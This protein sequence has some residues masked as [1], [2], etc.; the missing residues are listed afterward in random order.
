MNR[1]TT[2][3]TANW[4]EFLGLRAHGLRRPSRRLTPANIIWIQHAAPSARSHRRPLPISA[5]C[6]VRDGW[7]TVTYSVLWL[8]GLIA[9]ALCWF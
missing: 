6:R 1:V 5:T 4:C 9:I 7:E 2:K 3:N 8:C